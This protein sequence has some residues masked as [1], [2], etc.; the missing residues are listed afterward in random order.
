MA[1]HYDGAIGFLW[2]G[3]PDYAARCL[4]AVVDAH[5]GDVLVVATTPKVPIKGM[6]ISLGRRIYWVEPGDRAISWQGLGLAVPGVLFCGV[7]SIPAFDC[8]IRECV[9]KNARL[10]LMS[11]HNW[12]GTLRQI[13]FERVRHRIF[14]R[15][16]FRAAFVPGRAGV[17]WATAMGYRGSEISTG[18]YGADS[19]IFYGGSPLYLREKTFL[20]VGQFVPRKNVMGVA[21]AFIRIASDF[22]E[23]K[24]RLCGAGW[25]RDQIPEHP[26]IDVLEFVQ[27]PRLSELLCA[28]RCLVLPSLKE[29]WGLVVHEAVLTGCA[30]ALTDVV[31]AAH[32]LAS[33]ANA[34]LFSPG[35]EGS[36]EEGLRTIASWDEHRW[37]DA[38]EASRQLAEQFGPKQFAAAVKYLVSL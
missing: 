22:P 38:E 5:S 27:P 28:S 19:T 33:V 25:Q 11:D 15:R 34:V 1:E 21:R 8:L 3:L 2:A 18:L 9:Q 17:R 10:I 14:Y 13:C 16:K 26:Q 31:G 6:E 20:F 35:D 7:A 4:R 29:H 12:L 32:D 36:I 30:L 23:W 24:L 37:Q